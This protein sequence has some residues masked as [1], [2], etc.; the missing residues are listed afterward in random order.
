MSGSTCP[1]GRER[2]FVSD[3]SEVLLTEHYP[4]PKYFIHGGRGLFQD[5]SAPMYRAQGRTQWLAEDKNDV[6]DA[7]SLHLNPVQYLGRF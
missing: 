6:D 4:V 3:E 2:I 5:D 1:L 7:N